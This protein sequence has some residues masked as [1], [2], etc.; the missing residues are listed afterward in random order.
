M[1]TP[2]QAAQYQ[3][4]QAAQA[5]QQQQSLNPQQQQL[6]LAQQIDKLPM[7]QRVAILQAILGSQ[8]GAQGQAAMYGQPVG[9]SPDQAAQY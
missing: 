1:F 7:N 2:A 4:L 9:A 6:L 5:Q 8:G 3:A